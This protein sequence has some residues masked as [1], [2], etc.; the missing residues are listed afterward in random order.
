[1]LFLFLIETVYTQDDVS[2]SPLSDMTYKKYGMGYAYDGKYIYAVSG[3]ISVSPWRSTTMERY[4]VM[5]NSWFEF[6]TGLILRRYNST[7][8]I[9]SQNKL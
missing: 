7:E 4:D 2:F 5:G 1:M 8:Y 6:I 3:G 9:S